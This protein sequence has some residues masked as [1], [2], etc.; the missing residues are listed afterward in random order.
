MSSTEIVGSTTGTDATDERAAGTNVVVLHGTIVN[1]PTPV[2]LAAGQVLQFDVRTVVA[3]ASGGRTVSVPAVW[4]DP[5]Q[6]QAAII[7]P[8]AAVVVVGRIE[9]R[10][11]RAAGRTQSRTEVIVEHVVPVRRRKS[12]RSLLA[13][14]ADDLTRGCA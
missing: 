12:V 2:E 9:R 10:F 8:D 7:E 3:G 14:V 4:P 11:F 6:R 1:E 5:G 13:S